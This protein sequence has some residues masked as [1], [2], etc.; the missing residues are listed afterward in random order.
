MRAVAAIA[1]AVSLGACA[2]IPRPT[3]LDEAKRVSEGPQA[4]HAKRFAPQAFAAAERLREEAEALLS[5]DY[6][7]AQITGERALAAYARALG[8]A[9]LAKAELEA[10]QA[11]S[12]LE[13]VG[14]ERAGVDAE[15]QR[16]VAEAEAVELRLRT[17]RDAQPLVPSGKADPE[18]EAA[19]LA[20]AR[21]MRV[22]GEMLCRAAKLLVGPDASKKDAA[23]EV[24][25]ALAEL[26]GLEK[27]L[28]GPD[29]G[30]VPIDGATRARARCLAALTKVRRASGDVSKVPG[31]GD[32]LLASLSAAS[33]APSRDDRGVVVAVKQP[34]SGDKLTKEAEQR[35]AELAKIAKAN[36]GYP[37]IVVV[38]DPKGGP[39]ERAA[40]D[41]RAAAAAKA[42]GASVSVVAGADA[43]IV[44]PKG[45]DKAL[46]ARVE[47]VF[48]S[49]ESP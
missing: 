47:V 19:R 16:L 45:P 29:A 37:L 18:R 22:Q 41:A 38:H 26:D 23:A 46:N 21:S 49:P 1:L 31:K 10:A 25:A 36:P 32:A 39:K 9:R 24:D 40:L 27:K 13:L 7:G 35:L 6:A 28:S 17:L 4:A 8:L 15:L 44:D 12:E 3:V 14:K 20:A 5:K 33:L 34:W 2:P 48:V 42:V 11:R 30:A 43:P